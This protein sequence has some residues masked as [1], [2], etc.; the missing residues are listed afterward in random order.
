MTSIPAS[1]SGRALL[2]PIAADSVLFIPLA[3]P[4]VDPVL[5]FVFG[6]SHRSGP[7]GH[8]PGEDSL[9]DL[10]VN[11]ALSEPGPMLNFT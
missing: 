6:P 2:V 7:Y 9:G 10:V 11:R 3:N 8:R 5:D 4:G 1:R